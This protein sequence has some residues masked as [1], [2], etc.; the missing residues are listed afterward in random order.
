MYQDR[1]SYRRAVLEHCPD[2]AASWNDLGLAFEEQGRLDK[3]D[4][5]N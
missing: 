1:E 4:L 5:G 2:D 3:E